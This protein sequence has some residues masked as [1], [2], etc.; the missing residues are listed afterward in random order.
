MG[1]VLRSG[2]TLVGVLVLGACSGASGLSAADKTGIMADAKARLLARKW[3]SQ[4]FQMSM[5]SDV[6][7]VG[8]PQIVDTTLGKDTGKVKMI[9][10]IIVTNPETHFGQQTAPDKACYGFA[11]PGWNINEPYNVTYEFQ[12]EHWESGWRVSQIQANGF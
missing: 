2:T 10:P 3:Q 5:C 7:S 4:L 11:H 8:D 12:I 1:K 6:F 9:I